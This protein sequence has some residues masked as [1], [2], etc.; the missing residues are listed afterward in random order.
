[1]DWFAAGRR[2]APGGIIAG[3]AERLGF[4]P[5]I[6]VLQTVAL[7]HLAK[8]PSSTATASGL[9]FMP[10]MRGNQASLLTSALGDLY[11]VE[12][13]AALHRAH[14]FEILVQLL[15]VGVPELFLEPLRVFG[16]DRAAVLDGAD[17]SGALL[18]LREV[19]EQ[20][21]QQLRRFDAERCLRDTL[22]ALT[23]DR[24]ASA[25]ARHERLAATVACKAAVKAGD[26][27][28]QGAIG[29]VVQVIGLG[30]HRVEVGRVDDR[31]RIDD[32]RQPSVDRPEV[33]HLDAVRNDLHAARVAADGARHRN[34]R[35]RRNEKTGLAM[36]NHRRNVAS[37]R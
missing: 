11:P 32:A 27:I 12:L 17:A 7:V 37:R 23:G 6:T 4:E 36:T 33:W 25:H 19:P 15:P 8:P 28:Q 21:L 16:H 34:G 10:G 9:I 24:Q 2:G 14:A 18:G 31:P 3:M 29:R 13:D 20:L 26:L 35:F 22:Q 1:M 30:P 5:R